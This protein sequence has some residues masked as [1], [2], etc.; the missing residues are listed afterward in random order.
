M[1]NNKAIVIQ[2]DMDKMFWKWCGAI[3]L[4][5]IPLILYIIH[6][7]NYAFLVLYITTSLS[8]LACL[9]ETFYLSK[10]GIFFTGKTILIKRPFHKDIEYPL[11]EVKWS[12]NQFTFRGYT[13]YIYRSNKKIIRISDSWK[14]YD[15]LMTFSPL[16]PNRMAV[17]DL[18]KKRNERIKN[19]KQFKKQ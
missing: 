11:I 10:C 4:N 19:E 6:N 13:I 17:K 5:T 3:A 15:F 16:Y 8:I 7:C 12:A 2:W 9:Y 18:I 14:N 1:K